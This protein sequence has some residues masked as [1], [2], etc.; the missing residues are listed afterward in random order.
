M[1]RMVSRA[2]SVWPAHVRVRV[3]QFLGSGIIHDI[4]I[5]EAEFAD[6]GGGKMRGNGR[7][8]ATGAQSQDTGGL[9]FLFASGRLRASGARSTGGF[10]HCSIP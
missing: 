7:A 9:D 6:A 2:D 4:E 1:P 8:E 10:R 5:R 3:Q